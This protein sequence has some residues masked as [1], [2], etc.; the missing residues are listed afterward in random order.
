MGNQIDNT[1]IR[2]ILENSEMKDKF[3]R[4]FGE[5][6]RQLTTQV[7]LAQIEECYQL[8]LPEM[9]MHFELGF[10]QP[11]EHLRRPAPDGGRLHALLEP[12]GGPDAQRGEKAP[13]LLLGPGEGVVQPLRPRCSPTWPPSGDSA[14]RRLTKATARSAS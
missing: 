6:F 13:H 3:L 1:L 11:E 8:L 9:N 2:K 14:G 10:L 7:M 5:I 4:R 12:A